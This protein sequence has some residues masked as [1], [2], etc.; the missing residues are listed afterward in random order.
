MAARES[1]KKSFSREIKFKQTKDSP[2]GNMLP[3]PVKNLRKVGLS[4]ERRPISSGAN[5]W[6]GEEQKNSGGRA[7]GVWK[8]VLAKGDGSVRIESSPC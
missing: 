8:D 3:S 6:A 4:T 5:S 2:C 1:A 7:V